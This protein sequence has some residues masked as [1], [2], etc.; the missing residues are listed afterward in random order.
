[1]KPTTMCCSVQGQLNEMLLC[2]TLATQLLIHLFI[3]PPRARELSRVGEAACG[4]TVSDQGS[5]CS[6]RCAPGSMKA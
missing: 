4:H 3:I 6:Y 2:P 1:M 5:K